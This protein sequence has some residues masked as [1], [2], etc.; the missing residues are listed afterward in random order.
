MYALNHKND[1]TTYIIQRN[2][3]LSKRVKPTSAMLQK[4]ELGNDL[5]DLEAENVR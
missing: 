2:I 3:K 4:Q 5:I 1:V